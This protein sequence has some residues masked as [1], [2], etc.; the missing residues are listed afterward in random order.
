MTKAE[1]L[2][3]AQIEDLGQ[4]IIK[5]R[6]ADRHAAYQYAREVYDLAT[7]IQYERGIAEAKVMFAVEEYFGKANPKQAIK[8]LEEAL[9]VLAHTDSYALTWLYS[10]YG[11][12][13]WRMGDFDL[14]FEY[15]QKS[16]ENA[17]E[18]QDDMS[19]SWTSYLVA[20][21]YMDM[22]Q[23]ENAEK[24][25]QEA[26]VIFEKIKDV[27]GYT[28]GLCGLGNVAFARKNYQEAIAYYY[29]ALPTAL[30]ASLPTVE[31][32]IYNDL[33]V[34]YEQ[35]NECK[36]S[37]DYLLKSYQIRLDI[38]NILGM[39]TTELNLGRIYTTLEDYTQAIF[40][41]QKAIESATQVLAQPRLQ[42]AYQGLAEVH[43]ALGKPKEA[44]SYYEKYMEIHTIVV[45]EENDA[46]YANLEAKYDLEKSKQEAEIHKL[47]NIELKQASD[48]IAQQNIYIIE[49]RSKSERLLLNILP[50]E[51][52]EE[53][54]ERGQATPKHYEKTTILFTDFKG[55]TQLVEKL[56]PQEVIENL[57]TCFLAFDEICETY[58]LEKIKTIGDAYMAVA[59][60]PVKN[61]T[62]PVDAVKAGLAM[63]T[64]MKKW[65]AEK[66]LANLPAW[67]LR[68]GIHTGA[69]IAGVIGKSKIAYDVWGD[70][71][72]IAARMES[73]GEA[74]KVNISETTYNLVKD[75]FRCT[76]RGLIQAKNKGEIQMFFVE[77]E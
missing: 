24:A 70:A 58:N 35:L 2:V 18:R 45:G 46:K 50:E 56:P 67:E 60:I 22:K 11:N 32:R 52:A 3:I 37:I 59:G 48:L 7:S 73:S 74:G 12:I 66:E 29:K 27:E 72:N 42:R 39:T 65:K 16:I 55:F 49:E 57:N 36:K 44:L 71:V 64:F 15:T 1:N 6:I 23:F 61:Q 63:Q 68:V 43:K 31:A 8:Y 38:K 19:I 9:M 25:Y 69:L 4:K 62:N 41:Y 17:R 14:G 21:F 40:Y 76:P 53:L 13:Y 5:T 51:I 33:G 77:N 28:S 10:V 20:S 34:A 54:K 47:K 75:H 30:Q 26:V